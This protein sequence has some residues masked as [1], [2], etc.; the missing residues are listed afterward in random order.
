[1][2]FSSQNVFDVWS[3]ICVVNSIATLANWIAEILHRPARRAKERLK[4]LGIQNA[5][6]HEQLKRA[7][8]ELAS[9]RCRAFEVLAS[10]KAELL[11]QVCI[12]TR[13]VEILVP[14]CAHA[15]ICTDFR[16][17]PGRA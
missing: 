1:M 3:Q 14:S 6:A 11:S 15:W 7:E 17:S 4:K 13:L 10:K 12:P 2:H 16:L 5:C 8:L 9:L